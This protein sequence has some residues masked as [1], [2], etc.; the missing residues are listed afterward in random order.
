M[1]L[2]SYVDPVPETKRSCWQCRK[3]FDFDEDRIR[4]FLMY[5]FQIDDAR[6]PFKC[7][8][9]KEEFQSTTGQLNHLVQK[10]FR[11]VLAMNDDPSD[12][13]KEQIEMLQDQT[14]DKNSIDSVLS[15]DENPRKDAATR[16]G[17]TMICS[18]CDK[19]FRST[20]LFTKHF[21]AKHFHLTSTN[22]SHDQKHRL[23]N[24]NQQFICWICS[25]EFKS[26]F[27]RLKHF[28]MNHSEVYLPIPNNHHIDELN[29]EQIE[30][31]NISGKFCWQC[32]KKFS[33]YDGQVHHFIKQH[34]QLIL[35][36]DNDPSSVLK[37]QME[38]VRELMKSK[39][40]LKCSRCSKSFQTMNDRCRHFT[41]EHNKSITISTMVEAQHVQ[42]NQEE[43]QDFFEKI[44][45]FCE[46]CQQRFPRADDH[47]EHFQIKHSKVILSYKTL[48]EFFLDPSVMKCSKAISS[49]LVYM[50]L[51]STRKQ[52]PVINDTTNH[53]PYQQCQLQRINYNFQDFWLHL[54]KN[55]DYGQI[56][57]ECC[58]PMR[59]YTL[60]EYQKHILH[61]L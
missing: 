53:C 6:K 40:P 17:K 14:M 31:D 41:I 7:W 12:Y 25:N 9:C 42:I 29:S 46:K 18:Q 5:H 54:I 58:D 22:N 10:H 38:K 60:E 55:H 1:D 19:K 47:L 8:I 26:A 2:L 43:S 30:N 16:H 3:V 49:T 37:S 33:S 59:M 15:T 23:D 36:M 13:L 35:S 32:A 50:I 34:C 48:G 52:I 44:S 4:H 21:N 57:M 61:N 20:S 28:I 11:N 51:E 56:K 45:Y 27:Y 24:F 39:S